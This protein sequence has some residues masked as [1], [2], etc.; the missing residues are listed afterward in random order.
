M[1]KSAWQVPLPAIYHLT[2]T[3]LDSLSRFAEA[4]TAQV[5][6]TY[7]GKKVLIFHRDGKS[8][9]DIRKLLHKFGCEQFICC[10]PET[11]PDDL[12][13]RHVTPHL[14]GKIRAQTNTGTALYVQAA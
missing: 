10:F 7:S 4:G 1:S 14:T 6:D 11:L 9:D 13:R 5:L 3:G 8:D 2:D 12:R